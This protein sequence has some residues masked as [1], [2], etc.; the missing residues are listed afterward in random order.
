M[1]GEQNNCFIDD[2]INTWWHRINWTI[3]EANSP[4]YSAPPCH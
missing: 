2:E 4:V 1:V 3:Y